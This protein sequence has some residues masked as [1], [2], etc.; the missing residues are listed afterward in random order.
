MGND[1]VSKHT[2]SC[3]CPG[4]IAGGCIQTLPTDVEWNRAGEEARRKKDDE[5]RTHT[6]L[7]PPQASTP[8]G[9]RMC[10]V[11]P[12][13]RCRF[14]VF[15]AVVSDIDEGLVWCLCSGGMRC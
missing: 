11:V 6:S 4:G 7:R 15:F 3:P 2:N 8:D 9:N 5:T 13:V 10:R 14:H 1:P 12:L